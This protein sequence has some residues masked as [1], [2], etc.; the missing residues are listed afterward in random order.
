MME[1]EDLGVRWRQEL[2]DIQYLDTNG[3]NEEIFRTLLRHIKAS[4]PNKQ[5]H[6]KAIRISLKQSIFRLYV[7]AFKMDQKK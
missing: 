3:M 7:S 4:E 5:F 6:E 2:F 1:K